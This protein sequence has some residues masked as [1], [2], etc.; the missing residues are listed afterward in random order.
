VWRSDA[1]ISFGRADDRWSIQAFVRNI[2][3][4]RTPVFMSTHPTANILIAGTTPPRT[5]G[6]RGSFR[7]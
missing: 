4:N 7:F 5:Y 2:E 1:Q 6:I 3:N